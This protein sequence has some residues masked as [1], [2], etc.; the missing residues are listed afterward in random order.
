M[1]FMWAGAGEFE[2]GKIFNEIHLNGNDFDGLATEM[3]I[4]QNL[5]PRD[6]NE[7]IPFT[8]FTVYNEDTYRTDNFL[9]FFFEK[10]EI[11]LW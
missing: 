7:S 8:V 4:I 9:S 11:Y 10:R 1:T 6:E 5:Q 3:F 2:H